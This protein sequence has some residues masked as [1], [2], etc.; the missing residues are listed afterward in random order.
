[1]VQGDLEGARLQQSTLRRSKR[2]FGASFLVGCSTILGFLLFLRAPLDLVVIV[3][4]GMASTAFAV[5]RR[6]PPRPP[7]PRVSEK[8]TRRAVVLVLLGIVALS[9][10]L[11][12][13]WRGTPPGFR[14]DAVPVILSGF[15][16]GF[17]IVVASWSASRPWQACPACGGRLPGG[18]Q[19][20]KCPYCGHLFP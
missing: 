14:E 3:G 1:M 2:V 20:K 16:V 6:W 18:I 19:I 11:S 17:I 8:G 12:Y 15:A 10:L 13:D 4:I 5:L 7:H 9:T